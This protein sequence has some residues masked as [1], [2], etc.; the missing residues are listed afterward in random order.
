M[1]HQTRIQPLVNSIRARQ[2]SLD[3]LARE[4]HTPAILEVFDKWDH[5]S[6]CISVAGDSLGRLRLFTEQNFSVVETIGVVA[7][8][9]Y[10]F[11]LSI[12]LRLFAI[13]RRY[14]LVYF[15]QLLETQQRFYKDTLAQLRREVAWLKSLEQKEANSHDTLLKDFDSAGG[16]V[17]KAQKLVSALSGISAEIDAEAARRFSIYAEA[18]RT[19]GYGFQAYL[20][21]T[22]ALPPIHQ[23]LADIAAE[24]DRFETRVAPEIKALRPDRWQWR[25]MA[26][27]VG[28][29]D[30]YDYLYS[31]ASKLLHA[32][33]AS[34]TTD[35]KNLEVQEMELFLKYV[36]VTIGDVLALA[37]EYRPGAVAG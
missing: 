11:E 33:P 13:N 37:G 6:W 2:S 19:N 26:Q 20:V 31:F 36:D 21:E 17:G 34:I 3:A 23:A 5:N 15:D 35:Q 29:A 25:P 14:G 8:A 32:T 12:W 30:E 22:K 1:E 18:A 10:T 27:K 16:N 9:R 24:R 4:L 7:V 28:R